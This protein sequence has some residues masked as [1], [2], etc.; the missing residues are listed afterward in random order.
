MWFLLGAFLSA[1]APPAVPLVAEWGAA[2]AAGGADSTDCREAARCSDRRS[3]F[4]GGTGREVD[5]D[6]A[7]LS[8]RPEPSPP[9]LQYSWC[10][11]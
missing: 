8:G 10:L 5:D 9:E 3:G 2:G 1:A 11:R 7:G 6:E 4:L